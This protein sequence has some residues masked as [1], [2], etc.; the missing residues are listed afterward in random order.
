MEI[1]KV[2]W[3]G[4]AV[5]GNVTLI[6]DRLK[7]ACR[8][9]REWR[10]SVARAGA[11]AALRVTCSWYV[12]LDLDA[13]H[14]LRSDAPTDTDPV[15]TAKHQDR[16]YRIAEFTRF[17]TFIPPPEDVKDDVSD[18]EEEGSGGDEEEDAEEGEAPPEQ[19]PKAPKAGP[20]PP[21]V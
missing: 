7:D 19:A 4:E 11:N 14:S 13:L 6:S 18:E 10:C 17:R 12:Y 2:L 9:F 8:R 16:A 21:V 5:P 15:M 20:Q 3:P 1:F